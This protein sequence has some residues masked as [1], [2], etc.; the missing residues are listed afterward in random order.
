M[1]RTFLAILLLLSCTSCAMW[2]LSWEFNGEKRFLGPL[3]SFHRT[4]DSSHLTLRPLLATYDSTEG[5]VYNFLYPLGHVRKEHSYF[6]PFYRSRKF[7]DNTDTAF[8]LFFWGESQ[9][10]GS[11]GGVFPLYGR[12]Y[13]RFAKDEIAF[14]MWP[15]FSYTRSED[16][17]KTSVMWPFLGW[18]GG[19]ESGF[20]LFPIYGRRALPGT[21][22]SFF[23]LWPIFLGERKDLDT[24]EP[25]DNFFIFPF[26]LHSKSRTKASYT[27]MW[28]LFNYSRTE[29]GGGW[30][31][32]ADLISVK[33]GKERVERNFF[34][35][36]AYELKGRD[37][38]LKLL[39]PLYLE[40]EWYVGNEKFV[41]RRVAI[42]NRYF[43]E[44]DRSFLNIWPFFEYS[45]EKGD[46]SLLAPS[47][48]PFR[49][50]GFDRIVKPLYTL[51]EFRKD[52]KKEGLSL[53]YGLFTREQ[54]GEVRSTRFAFL[55]EMKEERGKR[56]FEIF[57]GLFGW[58][59]DYIKILFIPFKRGS[60]S[61]D[62][63]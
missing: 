16:A 40:S 41:H 13:D 58:S 55:L 20:R 31:V 24:E 18:Y 32:F 54:R 62:R 50:E 53:L 5:G 34:P 43:Q 47:F 12:L 27:I 37:R 39:G 59:R 46:Y 10:H 51:Y 21:R 2:P 19:M 15:L 25:V 56:S 28:P 7:R 44:K 1:Y 49:V 63:G 45:E 36:Y 22:E 26:Y 33:E 57:S 29:D 4:D 9:R 14:F 30:G 17:T 8:T 52:K 6:L 61:I 48:L 42:V 60:P 35:F 11:Y 23:F 38:R 3:I